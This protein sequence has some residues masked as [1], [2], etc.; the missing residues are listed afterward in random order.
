MARGAARGIW[1]GRLLIDE[2]D[3]SAA[4]D[5]VLDVPGVELTVESETLPALELR[6]GGPESVAALRGLPVADYV[7]PGVM[8]IQLSGGKGCES[9]TWSGSGDPTESGDLLPPHYGRSDVQID[10]AWNRSQGA[11]VVVSITGTGT[12]VYQRHLTWSFSSGQ[13][14]GRWASH[15]SV[16]DGDGMHSDWHDQ[17][18]HGTRTAGVP[19]AP[20]NGENMV[21]VAWRSDLLSVRFTDDVLMPRTLNTVEAIWRASTFTLEGEE[22]HHRRVVGMSWGH[23][24]PYSPVA[25][26]ISGRY[27]QDGVLFVGASGTSFW[28]GDRFGPPGC[29]SGVTFPA[30]LD[31]V[32]AVSGIKLDYSRTAKVHYGPEV[33]L[34]F[35]LYQ[36]TTGFSSDQIASIDMSSGATAAVVGIAA[37]VWSRYPGADRDW[38]RSRL[39]SSG[40]NYPNNSNTAGYGV[41]NAMKAV[42]G[43]YEARINGPIGSV[44]PGC[45]ELTATKSGGTGPFTYDWST[46]DTTQSIWWCSSQGG[47]YPITVDIRDTFDGT[48]QQGF[49]GMNVCEDPQDP[50]CT[51]R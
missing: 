29:P 32:I 6:A 25:D 44:P 50:N 22:Q 18:G 47:W 27:H 51:E 43:M 10:R 11:N 19:V 30:R 12:S 39:R 20:M 24:C 40:H 48:V 16:L 34:A 49:I 26:E 8:D 23:A 3:R 46:G 38:V 1:R 35:L 21:G 13:S 15:Q 7:E 45:Y 33:E 5:A 36:A 4:R 14:T 17:C 42:G 31:E 37:L 28:S 41:P 2:A 9:P